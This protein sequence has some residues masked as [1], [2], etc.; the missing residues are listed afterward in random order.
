M[1]CNTNKLYQ[2]IIWVD[3]DFDAEGNSTP[4]GVIVP[5][6]SMVAPDEET[7][8]I[9]AARAIPKSFVADL[10]IVR[11]EVRPF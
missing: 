2:Y 10:S 6:T 11:I 5:T 3:E 4:A 1:P 8:R 7:V 9:H